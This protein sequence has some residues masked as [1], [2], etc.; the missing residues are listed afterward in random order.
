M[1][2]CIGVYFRVEY[3]RGN[4]FLRVLL[5]YHEISKKLQPPPPLPPH[6]QTYTH[7]YILLLAQRRALFGNN[8]LYP[9]IASPPRGV[10]GYGLGGGDPAM[11]EDPKQ[12]G[13]GILLVVSY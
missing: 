12:G 13:L 10:N 6:I 3:F 11:D 5:V 1:F 4:Y 2:T 8:S 7:G 9:H